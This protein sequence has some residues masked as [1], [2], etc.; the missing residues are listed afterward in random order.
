MKT[1]IEA[2][3]LDVDID[4]VRERLK[5]AGA[6]CEQP[7]RAMKRVI[8]ESEAM[9][10]DTY[11]RIRDE[12]DKTT[13]TLKSFESLSITGAKEIETVVGNFDDIVAILRA[14]GLVPRSI[15]ESRRETWRL[16]EAEIVIDEWPW[17][18]PYIEIEAPSEAAVHDAAVRLGFDMN[19]AVYGDVMVAYRAEYPHLTDKDFIGNLPS[20]RFGDPLPDMLKN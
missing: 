10:N 8:I 13:I 18:R 20:V 3:F 1:E 14:S 15:Q 7:M 16:S 6:T 19:Q 5:S 2:K 17:L 4:D 12:G 11:L 9:G